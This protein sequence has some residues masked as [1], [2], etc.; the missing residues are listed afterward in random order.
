MLSGHAS[1]CWRSALDAGVPY[2]R[3][4]KRKSTGRSEKSGPLENQTLKKDNTS[5]IKCLQLSKGC[6]EIFGIIPL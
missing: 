4:K 2:N 1:G 3:E 6:F 5:L